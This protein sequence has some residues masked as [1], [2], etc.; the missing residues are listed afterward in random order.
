MGTNYY[1]K[2]DGGGTVHVGK[3]SYGGN[4]RGQIFLWAE[5]RDLIEAYCSVHADDAVIIGPEPM[6]GRQFLEFL[7]GVREHDETLVGK[8]FS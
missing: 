4:V 7:L 3:A 2:A 6:T 8:E 1:R 5:R